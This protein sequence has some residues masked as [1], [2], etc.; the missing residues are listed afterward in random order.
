[1][2][3]SLYDMC[4]INVYT[5]YIYYPIVIRTIYIND[6]YHTLQIE[7]CYLVG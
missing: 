2:N 6:E 1:M 5:V 4:T 3:K 7:N